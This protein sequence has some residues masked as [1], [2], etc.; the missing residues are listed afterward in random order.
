MAA[1]KADTGDAAPQYR[2][3]PMAQTS[4]LKV[5]PNKR[6][7]YALGS[8]AARGAFM[9]RK[10][11][12]SLAVRVTSFSAL[13]KPASPSRTVRIR[14]ARNEII[15]RASYG[16]ETRHSAVPWAMMRQDWLIGGL[17]VLV[18]LSGDNP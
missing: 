9:G 5:M 13:E 15:P 10:L 2:G 14:E 3:R 17:S 6:R 11:G 1:P 18:R 12:P 8:G 4:T 16:V 7:C